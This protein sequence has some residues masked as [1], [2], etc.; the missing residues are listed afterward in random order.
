MCICGCAYM[1]VH[2]LQTLGYS[3][4]VHTEP[5][6]KFKAITV[7]LSAAKTRLYKLRVTSLFFIQDL[8]VSFTYTF[9]SC[10]AFLIWALIRRLFCVIISLVTDWLAAFPLRSAAASGMLSPVETP[11]SCLCKA[12]ISTVWK[13]RLRSPLTPYRDQKEKTNSFSENP[14]SKDANPASIKNES[15]KKTTRCGW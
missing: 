2:E 9:W 3:I 15:G 12:D 13:S 5:N 1:Y 8:G 14:G 4:I 11:E 6:D 10:Q 7:R